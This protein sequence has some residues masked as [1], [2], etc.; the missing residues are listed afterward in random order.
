MGESSRWILQKLVH[1]YTTQR[2]LEALVGIFHSLWGRYTKLKTNIGLIHLRNLDL[3][4]YR[5]ACKVVD[6]IIHSNTLKKAQVDTSF[7]GILMETVM[8]YEDLE[9]NGF[10]GERC[11]E[12]LI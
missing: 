1:L 2:I 8:F 10:I 4:E 6:F 11:I 3:K 12:R 7:S 5:N 9:E